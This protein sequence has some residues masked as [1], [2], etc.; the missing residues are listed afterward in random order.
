MFV[1]P[2]FAVRNS[3]EICYLSPVRLQHPRGRRSAD[4]SNRNLAALPRWSPAAGAAVL[5][6]LWV[7]AAAGAAAEPSPPPMFPKGTF[8]L[9]TGIA[10]TASFGSLDALPALQ[11]GGNYYVFD[12][13]SLGT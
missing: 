7:P 9:D 8:T 1:G 6:A 11:L 10:Y 3:G 2:S 5:L 12:N 13:L 4:S